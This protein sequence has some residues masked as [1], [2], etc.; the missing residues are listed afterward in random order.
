VA[1]AVTTLVM[2]MLGSGTGPETPAV[3]VDS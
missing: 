3:R 2:R 1:L